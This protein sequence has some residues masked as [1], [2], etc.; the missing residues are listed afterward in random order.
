M[1]IVHSTVLHSH[2]LIIVI[3]LSP[4][5]VWQLAALGAAKGQMTF[6]RTFVLG[7][8]AGCFIAFGALFGL[9]IGAAIPTIQKNDPGLQRLLLGLFGLPLGLILVLCLGME[10]FTGNTMVMA[11]A[12]STMPFCLPQALPGTCRWR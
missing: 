6:K 9:S 12:V 5:G 2:A 3:L 1:S 8:V 4:W 11:I 7:I 10:L